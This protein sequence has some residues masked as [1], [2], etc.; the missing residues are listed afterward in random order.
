VTLHVALRNE[1]RYRWVMAI[2]RMMALMLV[3]T[4]CSGNL[5]RTD[6][7]RM[8]DMSPNTTGYLAGLLDRERPAS[9]AL[10]GYYVL[11]GG[12][13]ALRIRTAI[14][15]AAEHSIDAQYYIWSDDRSGRYLAGRILRA[16]DRGVQVRL[17]LDDINLAPVAELMT[18]LDRHPRIEVRVFNPSASRDGLGRWWSLIRDFQRI[19]RRMHNKALVSDGV[20]GIVGGRNIGD[21]YFGLHEQRY[22]ADRDIFALGPVVEDMSDGFSAYWNSRW[23]LAISELYPSSPS[24][25]DVAADLNTLRSASEEP[26]DWPFA[27]PETPEGARV[28][29]NQFAGHLQWAEGELIFDPPTEDMDAPADQPKQTARALYDLAQTAQEEILIESAY[30][31]LAEEQL[32]QLASLPAFDRLRIVALTN[33]LASNDLVTNHS[34]Y[35]RWRRAM[36][37][38]GI[39]LYELRPEAPICLRWL[40]DRGFCD[41]GT[42][43]LHSKSVVIDRKTVVIGSFNVNLRSIYLNGETLLIVRSPELADQLADKL[44]QTIKPWNSWQVTL[45]ENGEALWQGADGPFHHEPRVG[46]WRRFTSSVL[47]LLPIEKYL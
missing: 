20:A 11:D 4:G 30:L 7:S 6:D 23:S 1:C 9:D 41:D 28:E 2:L 44:M 5:P 27:I 46:W 33:S 34:A 40:K 25:R 14:V 17:L 24:P 45:D 31:V 35:A 38:Q 13:E 29:L 43:S 22:F 37:K 36:L 12:D 15:D 42:V 3:V 26:G 39:E 21:E 18:L 16:A 32:A 19:N 8:A 10:S 47:S